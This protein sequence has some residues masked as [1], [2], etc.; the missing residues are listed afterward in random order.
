MARPIVAFALLPGPKAPWPLFMPISARTG[1]FTIA[2]GAMTC[3]VA[4][5]ALRL[6]WVSHIARIAVRSTGA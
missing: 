3:V 4:W 1:P 5:M 2:S 6:K